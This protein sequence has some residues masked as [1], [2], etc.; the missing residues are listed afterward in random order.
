MNEREAAAHNRKVALRN[1]ERLFAANDPV[2][3]VAD[4][5]R[6]TERLK[7][8]T[9]LPKIDSD[10]RPWKRPPHVAKF[11]NRNNKAPIATQSKDWPINYLREYLRGERA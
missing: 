7:K 3:V 10:K 8:A 9:P 5:E 4:M 11:R 1:D 2:A 6:R